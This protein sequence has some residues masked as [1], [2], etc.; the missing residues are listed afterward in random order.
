MIPTWAQGDLVA[1]GNLV[2]GVGRMVDYLA[3]S[4]RVAR[5]W[6]DDQSASRE[7]SWELAK[8]EGFSRQEYDQH[9]GDW[10]AHRERVRNSFRASAVEQVELRSHTVPRRSGGNEPY[11]VVSFHAPGPVY[12][13]TSTDLKV[14]V[15]P[16]SP[17]ATD[18]GRRHYARKKKSWDPLYGYPAPTWSDAETGVSAF[19]RDPMQRLEPNPKV[20]NDIGTFTTDAMGWGDMASFLSDLGSDDLPVS[21]AKVTGKDYVV[22]VD[23]PLMRFC[24][25]YRRRHKVEGFATVWDFSGRAFVPIRCERGSLDVRDSS[26]LSWV[27]GKV[28]KL[29]DSN[30]S[31]E[32][33]FDYLLDEYVAHKDTTSVS[34][35]RSLEDGAF[36]RDTAD[37]REEMVEYSRRMMVS[38]RVRTEDLEDLLEDEFSDRNR[39]LA[40][41]LDEVIRSA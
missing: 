12:R 33:I 29:R 21:L 23:D 7:P 10:E 24:F 38:G 28:T 25:E 22:S 19:L 15:L 17:L 30:R 37:L 16:R 11:Y 2:R 41:D 40:I 1:R 18:G 4:V 36:R 34:I 3:K 35:V 9:H 5:K 20:E 13:W 31:N 32:Y 27:L 14:W 26:A 6:A 39:Y 8:G